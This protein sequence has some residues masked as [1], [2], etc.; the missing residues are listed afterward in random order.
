[1]HKPQRHKLMGSKREPTV[2]RMTS[3]QGVS[4]IG[5]MVPS[6]TTVTIHMVPSGDMASPAPPPLLS[7]GTAGGGPGP[8]EQEQAMLEPPGQR[9]VAARSGESS[10]DVSG[11][12]H[13]ESWRRRETE[14]AGRAVAMGGRGGSGRLGTGLDLFFLTALDRTRT[15]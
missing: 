12:R 6:P 9:K 14:V 11:R 7:E 1:M 3:S 13:R 5:L 4:L 10:G 2:W 8:G 15:L